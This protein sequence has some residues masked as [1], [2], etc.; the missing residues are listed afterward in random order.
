[1]S[2]LLSWSSFLVRATKRKSALNTECVSVMGDKKGTYQD[3]GGEELREGIVVLEGSGIGP[4]R[5]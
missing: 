3:G 1:M 5:R 2:P 4:L